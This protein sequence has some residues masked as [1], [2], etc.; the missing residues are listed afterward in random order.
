MERVSFL[1]VSTTLCNPQP[2]THSHHTHSLSHAYYKQKTMH[3]ILIYEENNVAAAAAKN[4]GTPAISFGRGWIGKLP[5]HTQK[6]THTCQAKMLEKNPIAAALTTRGV[7]FLYILHCMLI[8]RTTV[9]SKQNNK[10]KQA[11]FPLFLRFITL[12]FLIK[13]L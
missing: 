1:I 3:I 8:P 10:K 5:F 13:N 11:V 4:Q 6:H 12:F 9:N 2:H 7:N